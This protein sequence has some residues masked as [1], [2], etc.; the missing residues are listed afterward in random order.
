MNMWSNEQKRIIFLNNRVRYLHCYCVALR[1]FFIFAVDCWKAIF[2]TFLLLDIFSTTS[3]LRLQ[4]YRSK[5]QIF[6]CC[7][8][9]RKHHFSTLKISILAVSFFWTPRWMPKLGKST[10]QWTPHKLW[11]RGLE[12]RMRSSKVIGCV[13]LTSSSDFMIFLI[14][15]SG[16][17]WFLNKSTFF[18]IWLISFLISWNFPSK[19]LK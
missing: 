19:F 6:Q 5:N 9:R 10:Q 1:C 3:N 8:C 2:A 17:W 16:S 13:T 14:R 15:A 4:L 11:R 12:F 18:S 7:R